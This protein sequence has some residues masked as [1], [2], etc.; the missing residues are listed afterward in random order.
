LEEKENMQF[1]KS[2]PYTTLVMLVLGLALTVVFAGCK[3]YTVMTVAEATR[4]AEG[5]AF[6]AVS[7]VEAKW[8]DITSTI[9]DRGVNLPIVLGA[10]QVGAGNM[11]TKDNLQGVADEFGLTTE[12]NAHVFM[13]KG[14]GTVTDVNTE[15]STGFITLDLDGYD[16]P[17]TVKF[18]IG[19]RIPSDE[20]SVRDAVGFITFGDF[21]EQTEYGKVGRELNKRVL[22]EVLG[23]LDVENL[24]GKPISFYGAFTVRTQNIPGDI[25]MSEIVVTP[26]RLEVGG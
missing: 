11:V 20:T 4:I 6:D 25:D 8:G 3:P 17:I 21:R 24:Q 9:V 19:K 7:F 14:E 1:S 12:G 10:M 5:D 2:T 23:G 26:T 15:K 18:Y 16:G 22:D 13:V